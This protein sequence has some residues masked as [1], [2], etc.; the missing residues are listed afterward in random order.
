M[1]MA[2]KEANGA[3][4]DIV[5]YKF[6][7]RAEGAPPFGGGALVLPANVDLRP[8]FRPSSNREAPRAASPRP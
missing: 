8:P 7:P 2:L 3:I 4:R 5:G 1:T 6:E